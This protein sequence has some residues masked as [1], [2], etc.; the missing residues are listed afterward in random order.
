MALPKRGS[1]PV[2]GLTG[3]LTLG[4]FVVGTVVTGL[5]VRRE[6]LHDECLPATCIVHGTTAVQD[7]SRWKP[8]LRFHAETP[9][10]E[11]LGRFWLA[12]DP[13][14]DTR[15][16]AAEIAD[17]RWKEQ[18]SFPCYY[19]PVLREYVTTD[20]HGH[21]VFP[22]VVGLVFLASAIGIARLM[23]LDVRDRPRPDG[24]RRYP[25]DGKNALARAYRARAF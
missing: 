18:P 20:A 8:V 21:W 3:W 11:P 17:A 10:R 24:D 14:A 25:F 16:R 1:Q 7:G 12:L 19:H 4:V 22:L 6:H 9:D 15:E 13:R 23:W 5:A 2:A